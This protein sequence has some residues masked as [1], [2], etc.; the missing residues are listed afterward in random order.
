VHNLRAALLKA[1]PFLNII[2]WS[3]RSALGQTLPT[4]VRKVS[5]RFAA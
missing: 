4:A 5:V 1:A 3:V 2:V